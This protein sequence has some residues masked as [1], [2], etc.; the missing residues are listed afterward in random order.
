LISFAPSGSVVAMNRTLLTF[1]GFHDP[2]GDSSIEG[3]RS[4]GP[5]LQVLRCRP[6]DRVVL[7]STPNVN[8]RTLQTYILRHQCNHVRESL[9][10]HATGVTYSFHEMLVFSDAWLHP[11][12]DTK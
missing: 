6:F 4:G 1:V 12:G 9:A 8:D 2:Y 5:I 3:T 10:K 7:F 11:D